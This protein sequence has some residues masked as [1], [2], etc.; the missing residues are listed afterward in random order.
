MYKS[1]NSTER[2]VNEANEELKKNK[3]KTFQSRDEIC[4]FRIAS[5]FL[6]AQEWSRFE[7]K[8]NFS[9]V[10]SFHK[11]SFIPIRVFHPECLTEIV[12]SFV[13]NKNPWSEISFVESYSMFRFQ[14]NEDVELKVSRVQQRMK[15]LVTEKFNPA[16]MLR[17]K[18]DVGMLEIFQS[19]NNGSFVVILN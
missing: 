18:R 13:W 10:N 9:L 15:L 2:T 19:L 5:L 7:R 16:R 17:W 3:K 14:N 11:L 12:A 4:I 8:K 6:I 1:L